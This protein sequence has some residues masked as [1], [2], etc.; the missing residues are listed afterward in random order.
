MKLL[1][2]KVCIT[3]G[4]VVDILVN[5]EDYDLYKQGIVKV[6][7]AFPYL[8]PAEREMLISGICGDCFDAMF[9]NEEEE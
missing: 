3:C 9:T 7:D 5:K 6:Q 8:K 4:Q 2:T 1:I